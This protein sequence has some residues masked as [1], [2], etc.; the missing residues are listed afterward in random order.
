MKELTAPTVCLSLEEIQHYAKDRLDEAA[1]FRVENHLL[2][3]A[4]CRAALD[5]YMANPDETLGADLALLQQQIQKAVPP[6]KK[7]M[8]KIKFNYAAAAVILI[9]MTAAA[10]VYWQHTRYD[11]LYAAFFSAPKAGDVIA[12]RSEQGTPGAAPTFDQAINYYDAGDF[13]AAIPYFDAYLKGHPDDFQAGLYAGIAL[14]NGGD[15]EKAIEWLTTAS[16]NDPKLF[17]EANWYL[18]LAFLKQKNPAEA[19]KILENLSQ[20]AEPVFAG[21]AKALLERLE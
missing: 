3:C 11:R 12:L 19:V 7:Q 1:R 4:L 20:R 2:D 5:A 10:V 14:L 21:K 16:I 9:I 18:A 8:Q 13:S 6:K 17:D 15:P